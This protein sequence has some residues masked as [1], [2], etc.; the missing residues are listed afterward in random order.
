MS[1]PGLAESLRAFEEERREAGAQ[2]V[3][4]EKGEDFAYTFSLGGAAAEAARRGLTPS[5][6]VSVSLP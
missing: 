2:M 6:A 5:S 4:T 3:A 1:L